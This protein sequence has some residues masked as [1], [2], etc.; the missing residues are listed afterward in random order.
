MYAPCLYSLG[1]A[2]VHWTCDPQL[3]YP[4]TRNLRVYMGSAS[5]QMGRLT[6]ICLL[7][8]RDAVQNCIA[9][10]RSRSSFPTLPT[11]PRPP[12]IAH[13][14]NSPRSLQE[15]ARTPQNLEDGNDTFPMMMM[16]MMT[17]IWGVLGGSGFHKSPGYPP[18]HYPL[19]TEANFRID[20][21]LILFFAAFLYLE[22]FK[23]K[24]KQQRAWLRSA[25]SKRQSNLCKP[26]PQENYYNKS[27][28]VN[29][30]TCWQK[31]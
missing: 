19:A 21:F 5:F 28:R 17:M 23:L 18:S 7:G 4:Y 29:H 26:S 16:M 6:M 31:G 9:Y 3:E 30:I 22:L 15:H 11:S 20:V 10:S 13:D 12:C 8:R 2:V 14:R 24:R 1:C 25:F 27:E